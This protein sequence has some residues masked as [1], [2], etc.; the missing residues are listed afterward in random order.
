MSSQASI[1]AT[2]LGA[3]QRAPLG[4]GAGTVEA[5]NVRSAKRALEDADDELR[6]LYGKVRK[7]QAAQ[8]ELKVIVDAA[9]AREDEVREEERRIV[10]LASVVAGTDRKAIGY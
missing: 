5:L 8:A 1:R 7:V 2:R 10:Y 4:A 6:A 9:K 3:V